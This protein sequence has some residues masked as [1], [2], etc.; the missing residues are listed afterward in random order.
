MATAADRREGVIARLAARQAMVGAAIWGA[1]FA[2]LFV[3]VVVG[4]TATYT[5]AERQAVAG[6][7]AGNT[8]FAAL[9]GPVREIA[10]VGGFAAW[11]IGS[12]VALV[13]AVWG[14]LA[15]TRLLRGEED[16]GRRDLILSGP[17]T[18][19]GAAAASQAGILAGFAV[20]WGSTALAL[21]ILAIFEPELSVGG[22]LYLALAVTI[23]AVAFAAVGAFT[24][25]LA[26]SRREAAGLAGAIFALALM[27]RVAAYSSEALDWLRWTTPFGWAI[28]LRPFADPRPALLVP[29][30]LWTVAFG[31]GALALARRRDVGGAVLRLRSDRRAHT[32]L[33]GSPLAI[34]AR[35][36]LGGFAGWAVGLVLTGLLFGLLAA[37]VAAVAGDMPGWDA[38]GEIQLATAEGY[39]AVVF[40]LIAIALSLY[41]ATHISAWREEES[42]GR[43]DLV[44]AQPHSRR[45]W[46]AGRIAVALLA[47]AALAVLTGLAAWLGSTIR[48]T[49]ISAGEMVATG[50]NMVPLAASFLGLGV[51]LVGLVPRHA[52]PLLFGLIPAAYLWEL[53]G[54]ILDAPEWLLALSPFH[55]LALLPS[56]SFDP[57]ASV[58][59]LG[60]GLAAALAG[61]ERFRRRD[62]AG[63]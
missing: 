49:G 24:A 13:A 36:A 30:A 12:F 37:D 38:L 18:R 25:Q 1:V 21:A 59:M 8:A 7:L 29:L 48:A 14:L 63:A 42:H 27:A 9:F 3:V 35:A 4:Y 10:T 23:T 56:A 58:L 62:L 15:A 45:E 6:E 53:T 26:S 2:L 19:V 46:L 57:L 31:A 28:E 17:V 52:S 44:L 34:S 16:E 32:E 50:L 47:I 5:R 54:A 61:L 11:R 51:L 39:L 20:L 40:L 22:G 60:V 43:L 33:L 41:G 55:H